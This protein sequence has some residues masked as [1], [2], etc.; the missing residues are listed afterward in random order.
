M[1]SLGGMLGR[2]WLTSLAG[3]LG[4]GKFDG[5]DLV[6]NFESVDPA[7]TYFQ[8]PYNVYSKVDTE[9]ERFLDFETW[10]GSPILMNAAEIQ[11][12]VDNLFIGNK[13]TTAELRTAE[14]V[15]I[16]LRNI[17]SPIVAFFS[18]CDHITPP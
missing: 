4:G 5:A 2:T 14:G 12:I 13:L 3:D 11:W 16:D 18:Q 6:Q 8:K 7:N 1:G 17:Q 9:A 10:W 15:S